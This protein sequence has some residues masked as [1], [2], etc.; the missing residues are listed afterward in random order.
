MS[1]VRQYWTGWVHATVVAAN[2][3]I[4]L[5][6]PYSQ[7]LFLNLILKLLLTMKVL[8]CGYNTADG[9]A[10]SLWWK[11]DAI[12]VFPLWPPGDQR[13]LWLCTAGN[14]YI[15][16]PWESVFRLKGPTTTPYHNFLW[17]KVIFSGLHGVCWGREESQSMSHAH[18]HTQTKA[19]ILGHP[20]QDPL[21]SNCL[22]VPWKAAQ[23]AYYMARK[24]P[25]TWIP[26]LKSTEE[27]EVFSSFPSCFHYEL[28]LSTN[29]NK[30]Q[31]YF[32]IIYWHQTPVPK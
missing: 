22:S 25:G 21:H 17:D 30:N 1:M 23:M 19:T 7:N 26:K 32:W 18:Q 9:T 13:W 31:L 3:S 8:V 12:T 24:E 20:L 2:H 4:P 27:S 14:S 10:G 11:P 15:N 29:S 6:M 28:L 16:M 5:A